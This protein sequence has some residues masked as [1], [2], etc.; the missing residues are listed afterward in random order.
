MDSNQQFV[1]TDANES[2]ATSPWTEWSTEFADSKS[3]VNLSVQMTPS[4]D[5]Q[6]ANTQL[7][8]AGDDALMDTYNG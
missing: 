5:R 3:S 1:P 6:A 7:D 4:A 8:D 2:K